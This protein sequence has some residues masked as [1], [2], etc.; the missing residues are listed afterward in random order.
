M[1]KC[2]NCGAPGRIGTR[3]E[4]C[5][6]IITAP[7]I[8]PEIGRNGGKGRKA[9]FSWK[10]VV[11]DGYELCKHATIGSDDVPEMYVVRGKRSLLMGVINQRGDFVIKCEFAQIELYLKKKRCLVYNGDELYDDED[12]EC[13]YGH[14][15]WKPKSS[16]YYDIGE[17]RWIV[18]MQPGKGQ[19]YT[20]YV[21]IGANLYDE[22][23]GHHVC[24]LEGYDDDST[25]WI[26]EI[27]GKYY[28]SAGERIG[29]WDCETGQQILSTK[30]RTTYARRKNRYK[31]ETEYLVTLASPFDHL[32][33]IDEVN[34]IY[35]DYR[36]LG[37]FDLNTR[38]PIC[39]CKYR[40][41]YSDGGKIYFSFDPFCQGYD[42]HYFE[43][44][45]KDG[46]LDFV[47]LLDE[48][49]RADYEKKKKGLSPSTNDFP[50]IG[51]I[52]IVIIAVM[53]FLSY[54]S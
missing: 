25:P 31:Y 23:D 3:C 32:L 39:M 30:Y 45:Y 4:Y 41:I 28:A 16:G 50:S 43:A 47:G 53:T 21:A 38:K 18:P 40:D 48:P 35:G 37:L 6:N 51:C 34:T 1:S 26:R 46:K 33:Y 52:I 11:P 10:E 44:S 12:I 22:A 36:E 14:Q 9:R 42:D 13:K 5:G 8:E 7:P 20:Q 19:V 17:R 54:C 29:L 49:S 27:N 2:R 15:V 24:S